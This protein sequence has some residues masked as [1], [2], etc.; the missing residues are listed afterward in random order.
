MMALTGRLHDKVSILLSVL[1]LTLISSFLLFSPINYHHLSSS[2]VVYYH[3]LPSI[4]IDYMLSLLI[5]S[6]SYYYRLSVSWLSSFLYPSS[7][8]V[9][10]LLPVCPPVYAI[11]LADPW[12][13]W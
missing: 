3:L 4:I 12:S 6:Y 2:I 8:V 9:V 5:I 13:T 10:C 1:C 7:P 11:L